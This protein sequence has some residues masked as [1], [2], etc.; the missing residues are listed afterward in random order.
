MA[1]RDRG[2][3]SAGW[4]GMSQVVVNVRGRTGSERRSHAWR[5]EKP[6]AGVSSVYVIIYGPS[7]A[8]LFVTGS[9]LVH[10]S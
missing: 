2:T 6:G 7:W 1:I 8:K 3:V 10:G 5:E 4:N 9:V